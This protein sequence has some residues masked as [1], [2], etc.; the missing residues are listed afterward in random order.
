MEFKLYKNVNSFYDA[1]YDTLMRHEAQNLIPLGNIIIGKEGK[2]TQG[3]RNPADWVMATVS[4]ESGIRLTGIMTPPHNLALY[5]TDNVIDDAAIACMIEGLAD[6][7]I[8]GV[9]TEKA[10][11][12]RY[13]SM[14]KKPHEVTVRL[15]IFELEKVNPKIPKIGRLRSANESDM[16][17]LPY[18]LEAF[19][20]ECRERRPEHVQNAEVYLE[21]IKQYAVLEDDEGLPVSIAAVNREMVTVCGIASVYTPPYFRGKGYASSIVAQL[22]QRQLDRGFA[23]CVLYTDLANPTSN[24]IYMKIGYK[25][26]ADSLEIKF[27]VE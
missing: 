6:Y 12:E 27:V 16:F 17:F 11:A 10:L 7:E 15:R 13:A 25:A 1:T 24:S 8:P 9:M 2:F 20:G 23:K 21:R 5:A 26:I 18:W 3:W 19:Y 14:T 22:S 4:D